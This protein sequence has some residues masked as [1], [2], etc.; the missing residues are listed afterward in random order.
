MSNYKY[1]TFTFSN[2]VVTLKFQI[3]LR[4]EIVLFIQREYQFKTLKTCI[5]L[6]QISIS[7]L[8]HVIEDF[9]YG[10]K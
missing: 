6:S 9:S 8:I 5:K 3:I 7:E 10:D 1:S 4:Y 2:V